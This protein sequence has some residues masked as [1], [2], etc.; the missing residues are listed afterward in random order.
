MSHLE[1][2]L[3]ARLAGT[4]SQMYQSLVAKRTSTVDFLKAYKLFTAACCVKKTIYNAVAGKRKLHIVDYGLSYGFQWPAL[5][6]L[7]GTREGGPPEVRMT[8]IDVPQPGFRPADQIEETGRRLSICA[9]APVRCAIQV[10]RHCRKVGDGR[11]RGHG[12]GQPEPQRCGAQQQPR[13]EASRV[14]PEAPERAAGSCCCRHRR[15]ATALSTVVLDGLQI[16]LGISARCC[17]AGKQT[18]RSAP[19]SSPPRPSLHLHLHLRRRPPPSSSRHAADDAALHPLSR[20]RDAYVERM[21]EGEVVDGIWPDGGGERRPAAAVLALHRSARHRSACH[22]QTAAALAR[23][24]PPASAGEKRRDAT[25][26]K[27][28]KNTA[29]GPPVN[30][31]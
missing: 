15:A 4:G 29:E 31:L 8:G 26:A 14:R 30:G 28:G 13:H 20:R 25:S 11:E 1:N 16:G 22:S 17:L 7:L 24:Q 27:P 2:T 6:F 12:Q 19:S 3:E 10:P 9:R 23:C 21:G 18:S 5:F